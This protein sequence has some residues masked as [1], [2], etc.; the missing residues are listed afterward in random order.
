MRETLLR[1]RD[2]SMA[3]HT[4]C[5]RN[6]LTVTGIIRLPLVEKYDS[7]I[8]FCSYAPRQ[9]SLTYLSIIM[10]SL[11]HFIA[12]ACTLLALLQAVRAQVRYVLS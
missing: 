8:Y 1:P 9:E 11:K 4:N 3:L 10:A 5:T 2:G 6:S 12:G 7:H